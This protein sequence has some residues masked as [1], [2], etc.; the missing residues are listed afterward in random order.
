MLSALTVLAIIRLV[1]SD[2][3]LVSTLYAS[4]QVNLDVDFDSLGARLLAET[5]LTFTLDGGEALTPRRYLE[6]RMIA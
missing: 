3:Q 4:N 1:T 6:W 2:M 5:D